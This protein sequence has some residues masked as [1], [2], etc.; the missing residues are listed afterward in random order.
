MLVWQ[1]LGSAGSFHTRIAKDSAS[2]WSQFAF[3]SQST[4]THTPTHMQGVWRG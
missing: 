3:P 1:G 2:I 4:H